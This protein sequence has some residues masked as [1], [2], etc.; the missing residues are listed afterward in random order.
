MSVDETRRRTNEQRLMIVAELNELVGLERQLALAYQHHA[1]TLE[2]AWRPVFGRRWSE[3]SR[4]SFANAELLARQVVMLGGQPA[5]VDVV[6]PAIPSTSSG[7]PVARALEGLLGLETERLRAYGRAR[8]KL[9]GDETTRIF[10]Q[11]LMQLAAGASDE[12]AELRLRRSGVED[13]L[14]A[15][16]PVPASVR[17][18]H[19]VSR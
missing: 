17:T 13:V 5:L 10:S 7:D 4:E 14:R 1:V 16:A 3:R 15:G 6:P 8:S 9:Q 11:T 2:G 12:V 18:L 19:P